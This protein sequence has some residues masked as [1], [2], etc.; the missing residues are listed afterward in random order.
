MV[1]VGLK[2]D[3]RGYWLRQISQCITKVSDARTFNAVVLCKTIRKCLGYLVTLVLS[4]NEL[5]SYIKA[6][7][8]NLYI[9][10]SLRL[11]LVVKKISVYV[12]LDI[13][14]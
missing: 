10:Q 12:K 3:F 7:L 2:S 9:Y 6:V 8:K 1:F 11:I 14:L 13:N 4:A 5:V